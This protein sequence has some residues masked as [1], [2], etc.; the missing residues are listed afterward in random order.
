MAAITQTVSPSDVGI[1]AAR[2][3]RLDAYFEQYVNDGRL[4]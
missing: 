2:L 1:D 4:P 3:R